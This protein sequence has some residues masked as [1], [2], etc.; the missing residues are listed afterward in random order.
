[1]RRK[2]NRAIAGW[3]EEGRTVLDELKLNTKRD[4]EQLGFVLEGGRFRARRP[5]SRVQR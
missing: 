5:C 3:G 4:Y 1:M 2:R